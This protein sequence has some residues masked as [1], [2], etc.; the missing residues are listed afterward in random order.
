MQWE[1]CTYMHIFCYTAGEVRGRRGERRRTVL[2]EGFDPADQPKLARVPHESLLRV[3]EPS[4]V[5]A[6][7]T[8]C[9]QYAHC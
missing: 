9:S 7:G 5:H 1:S 2:M 3:F 6:M 8:S 4:W